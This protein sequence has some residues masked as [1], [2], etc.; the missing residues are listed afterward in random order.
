[1]SAISWVQPLGPWSAR[2]PTASATVPGRE[3]GVLRIVA[4]RPP[5]GLDHAVGD[6][7]GDVDPGRAEF[8]RQAQREGA[9]RLLGGAPHAPAR[10]RSSRGAA[11]DLHDRPAAA[12]GEHLPRDPEH[13]PGHGQ[14]AREPVVEGALVGGGDGSA[15]EGRAAR[16]GRHRV[17]DESDRADLRLGIGERAADD[18]GVGGVALAAERRGV[19]ITK[20]LE[21]RLGPRQ[22]EHA[23]ARAEALG[24]HRPADVARAEDHGRRGTFGHVCMFARD[25]CRAADTLRRAHA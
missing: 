1:M 21:R 8:L 24:D 16:G 11:D 13:R 23:P 10:D 18:P 17:D 14:E 4:Q 9:G 5:L 2:K 6:E 22:R 7:E 12:P 20:A 15:A 3:H 19:R 25:R